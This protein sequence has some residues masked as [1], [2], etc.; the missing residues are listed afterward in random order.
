MGT[1]CGYMAKNYTYIHLEPTCGWIGVGGT[2]QRPSSH[3]LAALVWGVGIGAETGAS[4]SQLFDKFYNNF[5]SKKIEI[6]L[7]CLI[8]RFGM[9]K[10]QN[11]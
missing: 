9:I 1:C 2:L 3:E 6:A 5:I 11:M 7:F 8:Y 4:F 10:N